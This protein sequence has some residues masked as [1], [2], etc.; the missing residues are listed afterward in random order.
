MPMSFKLLVRI[1]EGLVGREQ[2][3]QVCGLPECYRL[4][5]GIASPR[6]MEPPPS[7]T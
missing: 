2:E 3:S 1:G 7:L 4:P 6:F 5:A